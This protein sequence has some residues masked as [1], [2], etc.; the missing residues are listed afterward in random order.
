M[1]FYVDEK[2]MR[3]FQSSADANHFS[4]GSGKIASA[5]PDKESA[6]LELFKACERLRRDEPELLPRI[7][8]L[9]IQQ[10]DWT[11][12]QQFDFLTKHKEGRHLLRIYHSSMVKLAEARADLVNARGYPLLLNKALFDSF[13]G[14]SEPAVMA[15]E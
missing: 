12:E 4:A 3:V 6:V 7:R 14:T 2:R 15:A 5:G 9:F 11:P 8:E 1:A 13:P 10:K